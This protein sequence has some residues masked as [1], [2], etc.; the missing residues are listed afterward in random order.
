MAS[1]ANEAISNV[2]Q[3]LRDA[4]ESNTGIIGQALKDR[5][6][7]EEKNQRVEEEVATIEQT[8]AAMKVTQRTLSSI[9]AGFIQISKNFQI[10]NK[11]FSVA[12][13]L[14]E[15]VNKV[16]AASQVETVLVSAPVSSAIQEKGPVEEDVSDDDGFS[17]LDLLTDLPDL[18]RKHREKN[19]RSTKEQKARDKKAREKRA[20]RKQQRAERAKK[21]K[22]KKVKKRVRLTKAAAKKL[23][24]GPLKN[25]AKR[26]FSRAIPV[27]GVGLAVAGTAYA[28]WE[29]DWRTVGL[30]ALDAAVG[31][32]AAA[33]AA[34]TGG[35]SL[36]AGAMVSVGITL[37]EAKADIFRE[38]YGEIYPVNPTD[39][40]EENMDD[41]IDTF[42]DAIRDELEDIVDKLKASWKKALAAKAQ[43]V[44]E[45]GREARV[46][47]DESVEIAK[48][49]LQGYSAEGAEIVV[50]A[51][52]KTEMLKQAL[53][54]ARAKYDPMAAFS[55]AKTMFSD[56]EKAGGPT[57]AATTNE[58]NI[59]ID[60]IKNS[61]GFRTKPY[62][63]KDGLWSIGAGH[64]IGDGKTLPTEWDRE[65]SEQE[66]QE[67]FNK[68]YDYA[69]KMASSAPG[70]DKADNIVKAGIINLTYK[71][72]AWWSLFSKAGSKLA[73]GDFEGAVEELKAT[74][75][76]KEQSGSVDTALSMIASGGKPEIKT[77]AAI[78]DSSSAVTAMKKDIKRKDGNRTETDIV[79]LN[80]NETRIQY[81]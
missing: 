19:K 43:K 13:T 7:R 35:A 21:E 42:E 74:P 44:V 52:R 5:R 54:A 40:D 80:I 65:F 66:I 41:A 57:L 23:L 50:K 29:G 76:Y 46:A 10:I 17:L 6:A 16:V 70:W 18:E 72:G 31:V 79:M 60:L 53:P 25:L 71:A 8:T 39:E 4:F 64:L 58:D 26:I 1:L 47:F 56:T 3:N 12:V 11:E 45:F 22:I 33:G 28:A 9:E 68:D 37:E 32:A 78:M 20:E 27:L 2:K 55:R 67:L 61:E 49:R 77:G 48:K 63:N 59:A 38:S 24:K 73:G 34:F 15:N 51:D 69:K 14:Q 81:V 62:K 75:W 36:V 30:D